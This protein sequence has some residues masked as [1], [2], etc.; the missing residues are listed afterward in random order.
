LKAQPRIVDDTPEKIDSTKRQGEDGGEHSQGFCPSQLAD[1]TAIQQ[2]S[3]LE[4]FQK[5]GNPV[6]QSFC[7][8]LLLIGLSRVRLSLFFLILLG[9]LPN[10]NISESKRL[11]TL[12]TIISTC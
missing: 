12:K 9:I 3:D 1:T 2:G 7:L 8:L 11:F 4:I 5:G 6:M 10:P